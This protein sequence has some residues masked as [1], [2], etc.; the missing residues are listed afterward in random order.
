MVQAYRI[1]G[2]RT[3]LKAAMANL[4]YVLGRNAMGCCF[5]TGYGDRSPMHPH[6]RPSI[7]DGIADPVPG[8]L[9][10]GPNPNQEDFKQKH[11]PAYPSTLPAL[12]FQDS[13]L[14]YA[15]AEIAINWNAPLAYLVGSIEAI[16]AGGEGSG[17]QGRIPAEER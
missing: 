17:S 2:D 6:H 16:K 14:S 13:H 11:C 8:L 12:S 15:S 7:A 4:D 10:G 9:V 3:Y 1:T 5:V